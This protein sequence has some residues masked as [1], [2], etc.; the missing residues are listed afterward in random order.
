MRSAQRRLRMPR[1]APRMPAGPGAPMRTFSPRSAPGKPRTAERAEWAVR[2]KEK[3]ARDAE[4]G[5][6]RGPGG[7]GPRGPSRSPCLR[8]ESSI[9]QRR[10]VAA[11]RV[12]EEA[13]DR[14]GP[15]GLSQATGPVPRSPPAS[16]RRD[17]VPVRRAFLRRRGAAHTFP[18]KLH[19]A[20]RPEASSCWTQRSALSALSG[21]SLLITHQL[22]KQHRQL[23]PAAVHRQAVGMQL[24]AP[25]QQTE[26]EK[27][28]IPI[29][30]SYFHKP[31]V[32]QTPA[33]LKSNSQGHQPLKV[34]VSTQVPCIVLNVPISANPNR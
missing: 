10:R 17:P 22:R 24:A 27:Q 7:L 33:G 6:G 20:E 21:G 23:V 12:A 5:N 1:R 11:P 18:Y 3:V 31:L 9:G 13:T 14:N 8:G 4:A 15:S 2:R 25:T 34:K 30:P 19:P 28:E 32:Q 16:G 29:L 26:G